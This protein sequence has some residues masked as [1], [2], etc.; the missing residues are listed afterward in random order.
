MTKPR[1]SVVLCAGIGYTVERRV[2][3]RTEMRMASTRNIAGIFTDSHPHEYQVAQNFC[4]DLNRILPAI[5]QTAFQIFKR[6]ALVE[7]LAAL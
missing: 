7:Q 6:P 5:E 2:W 4:D 3:Q 1:Y